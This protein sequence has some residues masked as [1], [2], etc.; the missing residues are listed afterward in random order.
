MYLLNP[1]KAKSAAHYWD[2]K[3]TLCRMYSTGGLS[4]LK[5]QI[6]NEPMGKPICSMCVN[7]QRKTTMQADSPLKVEMCANRFELISRWGQ[8]VDKEWALRVFNVWLDQRMDLT[9]PTVYD[10]VI[11]QKGDE[12][13]HQ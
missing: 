7:V 13:G 12:H 11:P 9:Q 2:G 3:D 1:L 10:A 5:Q 6:F 8:P 4:K